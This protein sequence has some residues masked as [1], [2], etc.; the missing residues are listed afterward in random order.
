MLQHKKV[1]T[2]Q[3]LTNDTKALVNVAHVWTGIALGYDEPVDQAHVQPLS[4]N[5]WAGKAKFWLAMIQ[6]VGLCTLL[7]LFP[8]HPSLPGTVM[9]CASEST[10]QTWAEVQALVLQIQEID[11]NL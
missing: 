4:T 7:N 1:I 11:A 10:I 8:F 2:V 3:I 5:V 9:S 6:W